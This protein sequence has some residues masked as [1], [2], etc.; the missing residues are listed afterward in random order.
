[1]SKK[2]KN[3]KCIC[4]SAAMAALFFVLDYF[5]DVVSFAFG[6]YKISINSL[7][8]LIVAV[9]CGAGWAAATGFVGSLL[10]QTLMYGFGPITLLWILPWVVEGLIMGKLYVTFKRSLAPWRLGAGVVLSSISVT[11]LNTLALV[12]QYIAY[13]VGKGL[14]T[15]LVIELPGRL[16]IAA[17]TA[18][19]LT[20]LL[21]LIIIPLK[22]ATKI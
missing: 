11:L 20:L 12:V 9:M 10:S 21:P 16:A 1:M 5:S 15:L 7:P 3:L 8:I 19:V 14:K 6:N 2:S 13:G 4:L 17:V 18:V 22:K